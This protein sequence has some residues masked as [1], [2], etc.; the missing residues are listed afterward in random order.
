MSICTLRLRRRYLSLV[1]G[2]APSPAPDPRSLRPPGPAPPTYEEKRAHE[3]VG[4]RRGRPP[5]VRTFS[6]ISG[7]GHQARCRFGARARSACRKS[8]V[9]VDR[10]TATT[11]PDHRRRTK[12]RIEL[13][14]PI[15]NSGQRFPRPLAKI[16][17]HGGLMNARNGAEWRAALG[18]RRFAP[19]VVQRVLF[20]RN[21]RP[22]A[23]LRAIMHQ[24]VLTDVQEP[25]A[26]AAMPIVRKSSRRCSPEN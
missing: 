10:E 9:A 15:E 6:T 3:G 4:R 7:T 5:H 12:S 20:E 21:A 26:G 17:E 1:V 18:T 25:A 16:V 2:R 11:T 19:D 22:P 24:P 13:A 14:A 23:L 8:P